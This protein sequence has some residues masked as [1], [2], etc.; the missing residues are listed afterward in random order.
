MTDYKCITTITW[1]FSCDQTPEECVINA[2][3]QLEKILNCHPHGDDFDSFSVQVDIA[4]MKERNKLVHIASFDIDDIF[5]QITEDEK[6]KEFVVN[7]ISHTVKMNS[8][9][10]H[11]FKKNKFC[12]S[13]GLEGT[14]LLLDINP[15]DQSPHFNLYGKEDGRL[16]LMTKDH[17]VPKSKGGSDTLENYVT[18]CHICNN[19]KGNSPINYEDLKKLRI[20]AKNDHKLPSKE[21]KDLIQKTKLEMINI[22]DR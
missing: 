3:T 17:V 8:Q 18:C 6:K 19:L 11:V 2:R 16:V 9:R 12:V 10:Y 13:C 20:L 1:K 5:N 14:S 22:V 15:G 21:I 7:G 4:Q